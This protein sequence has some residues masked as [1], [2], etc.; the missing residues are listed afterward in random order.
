MAS[1]SSLRSTAST[2]TGVGQ[3]SVEEDRHLWT[4]RVMRR[5]PDLLEIYERLRPITKKESYSK[6]LLPDNSITST[7]DFFAPSPTLSHT[8]SMS[9]NS[10]NAS[11]SASSNSLS[12]Y[13]IFKKINFPKF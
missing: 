7:Q 6:A 11:A 12:K 10:S 9:S 2:S 13:F 4:A 5:N 1:F 3:S 8:A